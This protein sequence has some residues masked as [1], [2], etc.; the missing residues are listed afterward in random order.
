VAHNYNVAYELSDH[1]MARGAITVNQR[2]ENGNMP[3]RRFEEDQKVKSRV[4][5]AYD[6]C[7]YACK[8]ITDDDPDFAEK[9]DDQCSKLWQNY[10]DMRNECDG[11]EEKRDYIDM[12]EDKID[13]V[14]MLIDTEV[15]SIPADDLWTYYATKGN[16]NPIAT[17]AIKD[18]MCDV[19]RWYMYEARQEAEGN[20]M[21]AMKTR[22]GKLSVHFNSAE[23]KKKDRLNQDAVLA[24]IREKGLFEYELLPLHSWVLTH[25]IEVATEIELAVMGLIAIP[26]RP[27]EFMA[28]SIEITKDGP[29]HLLFSKLLKGGVTN[30]R[31]VP[32]VPVD[33]ALKI[34]A[35]YLEKID[36]V[37]IA[38]AM[39]RV[40]RHMREIP[41]IQD[42]QDKSYKW[43]DGY[44]KYTLYHLK[45][46]AGAIS[47][48]QSG[49]KGGRPEHLK[50]LF[51]HSS[52]GAS[53][54]Y[55]LIAHVGEEIPA[56]HGVHGVQEGDD[57]EGDGNEGDDE[58]EGD[59]EGDGNERDEDE[60]D[61]DERDEDERD[62][63]EEGDD[64]GD[65]EEQDEQEGEIDT[66]DADLDD[67]AQLLLTF[68]A[69]PVTS[70]P[71]VP[72]KKPHKP[73]VAERK[74]FSSI[75][76]QTD[77]IPETVE[78][79]SKKRDFSAMTG[80]EFL[81]D[82]LKEMCNE[83]HPLGDAKRRMLL[84]AVAVLID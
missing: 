7:E 3:T 9:V 20:E 32:T 67:A 83:G 34:R 63:E 6:Y 18:L 68:H 30:H 29:H 81:E 40:R 37:S 61:E 77:E 66:D 22:K 75:A 38:T 56:V 31:I 21:E 78:P 23:Y 25:D 44:L 45:A 64:E 14:Q 51:G 49:K 62:E 4:Q 65:D 35:K 55:D 76:V 79:A 28:R 33:R 73:M 8:D 58:E 5:G 69:K 52:V 80:N 12:V 41:I 70:A 42:I 24:T 26:C 19:R 59:D 60:R 13:E 50:K 16:T 74:T 53:I 15:E 1:I 72:R 54:H 84:K 82:L 71:Q 2:L 48:A 47:F 27:Q 36:G 11:Y 39:Q 17:L 46:T 10:I 43:F 57:N